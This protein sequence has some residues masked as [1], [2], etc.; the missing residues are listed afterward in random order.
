MHGFFRRAVRL[1]RDRVEDFGI[2]RDELA[3]VVTRCA[4]R[5]GDGPV[6]E[7]RVAVGD[8]G[9]GGG[10]GSRDGA[11]FGRGG[12]DG[13]HERLERGGGLL[14]LL[15]GGWVAGLGGGEVAVAWEEDVVV[16]DLGFVGDG[17]VEGVFCRTRES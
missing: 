8:G 7:R 13:E 17:E 9:G 10:G 5:G 6:E 2:G 15:V 1:A 14:G 11:G 16:L 3:S 12:G 4:Q